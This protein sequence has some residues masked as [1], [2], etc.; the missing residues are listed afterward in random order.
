MATSKYQ[1]LAES[2]RADILSGKIADNEKLPTEKALMEQY[3]VSRQT[4]R[5]ALTLLESDGLV[6]SRQGSGTYVMPRK[7]AATSGSKQ[8]ALLLTYISDYIFPSIIRGI[9]SVCSQKGY[10]LLL[11]ATGNSM[12]QERDILISLL[13]SPPCALIVDGNKTALPNPNLSYYRQ[14][15]ALGIPI[16][17]IH[18]TYPELTDIPKIATRDKV[19]GRLAVDYL[20]KKGHSQIAGIFKSTDFQGIH[21]FSGFMDGMLA[22]H[23]T[24]S[25]KHLIWFQDNEQ[26]HILL[27]NPKTLQYF[28]GCTGV[29]CY[30]DQIAWD[31]I[32]FLTQH[33]L[34]VPEDISV[35][36]FDDSALAQYSRPNITSFAHPKE[37]LGT[38]AAKTII[39]MIEGHVG[40]SIVFPWELAER[41]SVADLTTNE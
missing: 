15:Q 14:L 23:L 28:E 11:K 17:F 33:G 35:I 38:A 10:T 13:E 2:I 12:E 22:N 26:M 7:R 25:D 41:D 34:R 9:E 24:F 27:E 37:K 32:R 39:Q 29:V 6:H 16:I 4:V 40:S 8:I 36:S 5:H 20:A 19:G 1:I 18:A 3:Q 30:N 21:R 31:V